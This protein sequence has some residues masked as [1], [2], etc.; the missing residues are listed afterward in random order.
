MEQLLDRYKPLVRQKASAMFMV[1]AD[2]DDVIQEG[3]IGLF[4]AIRDF[5]PD[6]G[7]S[8]ATFANRCI[9][10]QITDAVRTASRQKH[11]PLNDSVSLQRLPDAESGEAQAAEQVFLANQPS[12]EQTL[13]S[14]EEQE[15]LQQYLQA[16]LSNLEQQVVELH[17]KGRTYKEIADALDCSTKRIDNALTRVRRKLAHYFNRKAAD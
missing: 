6:Q 15:A 8:F 14:K 2:S 5:Q 17:L 3:M 9:S 7:A 12:P 16:Q 13:L 4:K 10:T 11:K 1:G